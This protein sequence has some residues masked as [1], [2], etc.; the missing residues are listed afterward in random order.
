[1]NAVHFYDFMCVRT[2]CCVFKT[3]AFP[4][5]AMGKCVRR[6][7]PYRDPD[8]SYLFTKPKVRDF[9]RRTKGSKWHVGKDAKAKAVLFKES[10]EALI[11]SYERAYPHHKSLKQLKQMIHLD[12][13]ASAED[14]TC[15]VCKTH[16]TQV[17]RTCEHVFCISCTVELAK[18]CKDVCPMCRDVHRGVF[19]L[20]T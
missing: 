14:V 11:A 2:H 4:T 13:A 8:F 3:T 17:V 7:S 1:M 10:K 5:I 9:I 19:V 18:N 12:R 6:T 15:A 20:C 16:T